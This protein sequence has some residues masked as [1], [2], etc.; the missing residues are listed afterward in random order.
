MLAFGH[1]PAPTL[2]ATTR[3]GPAGL[4]TATLRD[5]DLALTGPRPVVLGHH[6]LLLGTAGQG[7]LEV[8]FQARPVRPGTLLWIR[9]G[10]AVRLA[11]PPGLDAVLVT[12]ES[13]LHPDGDLADLPFDDPFGPMSWQLAGE[14]E[15][16]IIT[17]V[18]QLVVDCERFTSGSLATA[19]LRHEL[20]VLLLRVGLLATPAPLSRAEAR[21]YHRFRD[22]LERSHAETRRVEEYAARLDCSVRTLTRAS[23]AATG[24]SAKQLVDDRVT[25]AAQRLLGCTDLSVAEVGRRLGFPEPTNFGRF[26]QRAVGVSPGT[27]RA[28]TIGTVS[29]RVPT[30]RRPSVAS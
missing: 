20:A 26:F 25:L 22:E 17:E 9:P 14:D 7:E 1:P 16:A 27:F 12:W 4:A 19:L 30:P 29:P 18:S 3:P 21:T 10:Q 28:D 24:R 6:L 13:G 15:D 8:D 2:P 5:A 23:L 11:P